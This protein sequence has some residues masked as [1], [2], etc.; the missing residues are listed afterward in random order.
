MWQRLAI[1]FLQLNLYVREDIEVCATLVLL[2]CCLRL[3]GTYCL[4]R[5]RSTHVVHIATE[6]VNVATLPRAVTNPQSQKLGAAVAVTA[7]V[8]LYHS[9]L[10]RSR[11][12][13]DIHCSWETFSVSVSD[14]SRSAS[15]RGIPNTVEG[16]QSSKAAL[17]SAP[18]LVLQRVPGS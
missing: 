1:C 7:C 4:A 16:C 6:L 3:P 14:Y 10:G 12:V 2:P 11:W 18:H 13:T 9:F 17:T 8:A 15:L 5:T